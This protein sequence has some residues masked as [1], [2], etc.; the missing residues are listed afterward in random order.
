MSQPLLVAHGL[1]KL[2]T[3]RGERS[4]LLG[5]L[6]GKKPKTAWALRDAELE[7]HPGEIVAA[8]GR[9]GAGKSTLLKIASGVTTPTEGTLVRPDNI[10]PLIEV[11]A[12]FHPDLSGRENVEINARLLGMTAG[13]IRRRFDEIVEFSD[14]AHSIDQPV[15]QYSSGMYMRLGFAVAVHT[16]PDLLVVDEVLAVG[17]LPFQVKCLDR[18][19]ELKNQGVGV[20][21]V[22]HNLTAV[23]TLADRAL[24]LD[25]GQ[26]ITE[27]A[28]NE[29]VGAYHRLLGD[30]VATG[31]G[32]DAGTT[33]QLEMVHL[34]MSDADGLEHPMCNPGDRAT[35]SLRLKANDNVTEGA[36]VGVRLNK[37]GA[38]MVAHWNA[39]ATGPLLPA[40]S[41][42]D[43]RIV[44]LDVDL[45]L[46]EGRYNAEIA[47]ARHDWSA[48]LCANTA[49]LTF[50]VATHAGSK[51]LVHLRPHLEHDGA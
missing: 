27:G 23:L 21:F 2:Y 47:V 1:G 34:A 5:R 20:L 31:L 10:A 3:Q 13:Q 38:G 17:D 46:G 19:R 22:S 28:V 14:L 33:G 7:V 24:L 9:N 45:N 25:K 42:G 44:R 50:G 40:M 16:H 37:E 39:S 18:I 12:G 43:E 48:I 11:G 51:G 32:D 30:L 6:S 26:T 49:P 8:I 29:V 15:R 41:P 4:L 35:F 36:I